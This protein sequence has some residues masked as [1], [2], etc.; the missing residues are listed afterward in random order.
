[1]QKVESKVFQTIAL[2]VSR[3][4]ESRGSVLHWTSKRGKDHESGFS[5]ARLAY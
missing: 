4:N 2:N 5:Q 1:M 3:L